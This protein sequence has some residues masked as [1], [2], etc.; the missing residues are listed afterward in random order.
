[1][2]IHG[3]TLHIIHG[4]KSL[5]MVE[6]LKKLDVKI[7]KLWQFENR[8]C[9]D[10]SFL[11][12]PSSWEWWRQAA[13]PQ[14]GCKFH[15]FLGTTP[16]WGFERLISKDCLKQ[17]VS[18]KPESLSF[19]EKS[20]GFRSRCSQPIQWS[21]QW[22]RNPMADA[23]GW[24]DRLSQLASVGGFFWLWIVEKRIP[25]ASMWDVKI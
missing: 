25:R 21:L 16:L 4:Y 13:R 9:A 15:L 10:P 1:M 2:D 12:V 19:H 24:A 17:F 6:Y 20:D 3:Y 8:R 14:L 18:G 23:F 11:F 5:Y 22:N 7:L